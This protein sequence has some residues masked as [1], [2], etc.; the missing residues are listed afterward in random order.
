MAEQ[1]VEQCDVAVIGGGPGGSTAATLLARRG[2]KVIA[3]EKAHHP[4]FH[5]GESLLPMNLPVFERL[6]V[7]DKVRELGVFKSGADFEADNA[8]GYNVYAFARAI[9]QSPPHSYQVW[10][11]DFDRML[12]EHARGCGAD[13]REGHEV[14]RVEQRGPRESRLDVRTDDGR[15]YAIQAR[16]VVDASGRDALLATK[17]KL[18]RKSD[19][20]QSAAIFG[21]FRGADRRDGEDAGN[22]SIYRFAHGWMWMIPLPDGVMS[23]GAVCRPDYLKQRR[24]RTVEFL[25]DTLKL[26]LALWRRVERAGLIGNEVHVTGNYSYDATRMGGPGWVL[27]GD[28]FA[29][30]DPVFSSGVYLAMDGAERAAD[31]VDAALR[32]P[33]R[34]RAL[35]RRLERRQRKGMARFAFFIHRFNGPVMRQ[36]LR[37]PRNTWQ[38]EQAVI[39]MLAGDLFDTPKVLRRLQLFKLVHAISVLRDW[40][41]SRAER[42]DRLAQARAPFT[43]GD[44]PP[45]KA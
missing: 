23:V 33:R 32:E 28:A 42:R 7:L 17:M 6:G 3:L 27:V 29:F 26:N 1:E 24:G 4:R 2:Y 43:G 36:M 12:Y 31:M 37:S 41:R 34:E 22:V 8:R 40:R 15:D 9:G 16:Y 18:R 10:R 13:A 5:I 39:S 30:L 45:D 44:S 20:H 35:L 38:L 19:Q 14:R 21:H 25:L 11:Q